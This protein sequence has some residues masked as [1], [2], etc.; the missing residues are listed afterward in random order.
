MSEALPV[1]HVIDDDASFLVALARLL[2]A[3]GYTVQT[4]A[5]AADFLAEL[6]DGAGCVVTDLRMP[7]MDGLDL[8]QAL[9]RGANVLPVVFLT[10]EGDIPSTVQAMRQGAEDFLTKRAPKE[11][12]LAAVDRAIARN[13]RSRAESARLHALRARFAALTRRELGVLRHVV[14]GRLNKQ[15]AADLGISER[16]VKLH[17]TAITTKLQAHSV[18]ELTR[19]AQASGLFEGTP[20]DLP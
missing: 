3:S 19:L 2:K 15:I 9:K 12:L 11:D 7:G 16:T 6:G 4:H 10:G 5:S 1:V 17:R 18:A 14:T 8:Q 13:A 20:S